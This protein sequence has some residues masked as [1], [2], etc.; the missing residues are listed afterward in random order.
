MPTLLAPRAAFGVIVP[1]TNTA[2]E[3]EYNRMRPA[4]VSFHSGRIL[5]ENESLDSDEVFE[6]FLSQ[7]RLQ[8]QRAVESVLTCKPDHLILGMSAETFWGGEKGNIEF[9]KWISELSGLQVTSG[10]SACRAALARVGAKSISVI[11]PYQPVADK[12]VRAY[13]EEIGFEVVTVLGMKCDTA[14]AIAGVSPERLREAFLEVDGSGVDALVQTGT[15]L[16]AVAVAAQLEA[17]LGKPVIP[18][19]GATVW[20]ALRSRGIN[21]VIIGHGRLLEEF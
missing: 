10:A 15:N 18:I 1:S 21:D 13:F 4:G 16:P 20:H 19:N 3:D 11:T 6:A 2:V 7:L 12:Q 14:T 5:I 8:I 9:E 17:E